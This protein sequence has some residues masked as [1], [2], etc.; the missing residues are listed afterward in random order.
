MSEIVIII[1]RRRPSQHANIE[2]TYL[3]DFYYIYFIYFYVMC[4]T[5]NNLSEIL[6]LQFLRNWCSWLQIRRP[7]FD[8]RH[9]QK[10][11]SGSGKGS[12]Q[13]REYN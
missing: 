5:F 11:S 2:A 6:K 9:Y 4:I 7:G 1:I 8:S 10:K 13:S 12:T 3:Y